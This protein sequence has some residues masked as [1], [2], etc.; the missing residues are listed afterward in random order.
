MVRKVANLDFC[1]FEF[2]CGRESRSVQVFG[3]FI[4][5][6]SPSLRT[7]WLHRHLDRICTPIRGRLAWTIVVRALLPSLE[8]YIPD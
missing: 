4:L 8:L 3:P 7:L 2:C 1:R 6:R 5:R